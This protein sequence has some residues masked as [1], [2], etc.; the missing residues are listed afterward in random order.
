RSRNR[1]ATPSST[2]PEHGEDRTNSKTPSCRPAL[3]SNNRYPLPA[4]RYPQN[5]NA[6]SGERIADSGWRMAQGGAPMKRFI[7]L[8]V[9]CG[10]VLSAGAAGWLWL[11]PPN[12]E[13]ALARIRQ[14]GGKVQID[15]T[16]RD[17]P[18]V[19]VDLKDC[20]IHD[21]DLASLSAFSHLQYLLLTDTNI[22]E[23]G[24]KHLAGLTQLRGLTL[25]GPAA[26]GDG[27]RHL[28]GMLGLRELRLEKTPLTEAGLAHLRR[29]I[30]LETLELLD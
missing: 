17:R 8:L 9:M 5:R 15:E 13:R 11:L 12:Q 6:D 26:G 28:G 27:L 1:S 14:R 25:S 3:R 19:K 16:R 2:P 4:L 7:I 20:P 23:N 30:G 29:L 10:V 18:V 21:D 22:T 24:L